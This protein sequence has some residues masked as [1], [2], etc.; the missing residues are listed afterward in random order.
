[1]KRQQRF[2]RIR[3]VEREY[4][5]A[6]FASA[7]LE[8]RLRDDPN[9]LYGW[10]LSPADLR[11]YKAQSE[12][13]Y[14]VRLFSEFEAGLMDWWEFGRKR[15]TRPPAKDLIDGV[16][17]LQNVPDDDRDGVHAVRKYRNRCVHLRAEDA[18]PLS[19]AEARGF[20]CQFFSR[21][22]IDW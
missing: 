15:K 13:T 10:N 1:M 20:L 7:A 12:A 9:A 17:A 6:V 16:A 2:E 18:E 3:A 4:K 5:I 21:L 22:P 14:M 11:G 8:E 19:L